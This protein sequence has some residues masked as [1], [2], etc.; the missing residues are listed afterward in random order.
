MVLS[1]S[2]SSGHGEHVSMVAKCDWLYH[3][4]QLTTQPYGNLAVPCREPPLYIT[5]LRSDDFFRALSFLILLVLLLLVLLLLLFLKFVTIII[6]LCESVVAT[7][8]IR[9][10]VSSVELHAAS[11]TLFNDGLPRRQYDRACMRG[12]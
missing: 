5:N 7:E 9:L 1:S 11:S 4:C 6:T 8:A 12:Q 10:V 2:Q 3:S